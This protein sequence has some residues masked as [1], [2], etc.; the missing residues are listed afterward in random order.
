M[1]DFISRG[2]IIFSR[3]RRIFAWNMFAAGEFISPLKFAGGGAIFRPAIIFRGTAAP[4]PSENPLKSWSVLGVVACAAGVRQ[5][6]CSESTDTLTSSTGTINSPGYSSGSYPNNAYCQ[7]LIQAPAS[8][9]RLCSKGKK[10]KV[11]HTRL[12]SVGFR[13]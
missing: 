6:A 12:P 2:D 4:K 8:K 5:T 7:W 1:G 3:P 11:A 13:S 9:V 10:V